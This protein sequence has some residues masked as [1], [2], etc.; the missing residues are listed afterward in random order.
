[1]PAAWD[2]CRKREGCAINPGWL[3]QGAGYGRPDAHVMS[4]QAADALLEEWVA[5][6]WASVRQRTD[7]SQTA[8]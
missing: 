3:H 4:T 5:M 8:K 2:S 7:A 1:M 6:A